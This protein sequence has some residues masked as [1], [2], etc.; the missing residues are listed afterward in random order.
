MQRR[1]FACTNGASWG[2]V[3]VRACHDFKWGL[4]YLGWTILCIGALISYFVTYFFFS[5]TFCVVIIA[6]YVGTPYLGVY[7]SIKRSD[8]SGEGKWMNELELRT[9]AIG[10]GKQVA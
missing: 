7:D 2:W 10:S 6:L 4:R 9:T 8:A 3:L 1:T 5:S